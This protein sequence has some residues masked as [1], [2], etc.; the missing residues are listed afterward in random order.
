M[1]PDYPPLIYGGGGVVA[2]SIAQHLTKKGH[3]VTVISGFN[4]KKTSRERPYK[5]CHGEIEIIWVPLFSVLD[6]QCP[7][8]RGSMPPST[9]SIKFL[10]MIN[11]DNYDVIHLNGFG[12]LLIDYVNLITKK[13]SKIITIHAFQKYVDKGRDSNFLFKFLY[14]IYYLTIG[15]YTLNSTKTITTVSRFT[16]EE[17]IKR[18][19]SKNK[20]VVIEN[21]IDLEKY[22]IIT[23]DELEKKFQIGKEELLILSISRVTW[24]KGYEY[25]LKAIHKIVNTTKRSIK[26]M[27]MGRIEDQNYYWK[28]RKLVNELG[29]KANVIFTGFLSEK[30]KL[31]A[32]TRANIFL[33]PSLHEGFGIVIL[34]ALAMGKPIIASNCEG[35]RCILEHMETGILIEPAKYEKIIDAVLLLLSKPVLCGML[36][37][38]A[39]SLVRKYDWRNRVSVYNDIYKQLI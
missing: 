38:N 29:L 8:L 12:H 37:K 36:S 19:I 32:L 27:I 9:S 35:F 1:T 14:K 22:K 25:A 26:Y 30:L 13:S 33:A 34:E 7:Q 39:I 18:G 11:Y 21:G 20:V 5:E 15:K 16:A 23:Y 28:L 4:P 3:K 17:C 6:K 24:Y 2:Q 10:K 31:Q